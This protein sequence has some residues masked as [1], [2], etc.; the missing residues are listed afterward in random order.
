M[1]DSTLPFRRDETRSYTANDSF[2]FDPK[3]DRLN[4][5]YRTPNRSNIPPYRRTGF[6]SVLGFDRRIKIDRTESHDKQVVLHTPAYDNS[7]KVTKWSKRGFSAKRLKLVGPIFPDG[8]LD[9]G[10][11]F[12]RLG[13]KKER[14]KKPALGYLDTSDHDDEQDSDLEDASDSD[15]VPTFD[16]PIDMAIRTQNVDLARQ[17][18]D[19]PT[20][21]ENWLKFVEHQDKMIRLGT[22]DR[23]TELDDAE[24]RSL[25]EVKMSLY[26]DALAKTKDDRHAQETLWLG[27]LREGAKVWD[28]QTHRKK[29][30]QAVQ[31]NPG[32]AEILIR[33]LN[34]I[35]SDSST[36]RYGTIH[37]CSTYY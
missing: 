5:T 1:Q 30:D 25:A 33:R 26:K 15:T 27:L 14:D 37:W 16:D 21:L 20:N 9:H 18:K 12:I 28:S 29:W 19:Q 6:G 31:S 2:V 34:F 35:Q 11:S 13:R 3:G 10:A 8:P 24:R 22:R 7:S 17:C 23:S 32:S 36:F 4:F